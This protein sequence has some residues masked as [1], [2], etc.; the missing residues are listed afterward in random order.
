MLRTRRI[1]AARENSWESRIASMWKLVE[2]ALA[3]QEAVG[4]RWD[5]RLRWLYGAARRRMATAAAIVVTTYLLFF[6]TPLVWWLAEP[7]R[8]SAPVSHADAIVVFA[9]G[10]GESGAAGGGYQERVKQAV[11]LYHQ[12]T[13]RWLIFSS[14][15]VYAFQEAQIMKELAVANGVP[16]SAIILETRAANTYENVVFVR[17]I[18]DARNWRRVALVSSPY[19][20]RRATLTAKRVAPEIAVIPAPAAGSQFYAHHHGASLDQILG[21]LHEYVAIVVYWWRGWI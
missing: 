17:R 9:G 6:Q 8:M 15:F 1:D 16:P 7:L 11:A 12:G 20:M 2:G 4:R 19:H 3:E 21:I 14:G 10:V 18:L 13:A 5:E